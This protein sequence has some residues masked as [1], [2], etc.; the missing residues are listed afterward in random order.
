[1]DKLIEIAKANGAKSFEFSKN[2]H[3]THG[4]LRATIEQ[5]CSPLVEAL[6]KVISA[7]PTIDMTKPDAFKYVASVELSRKAL[8]AHTEIMGD[9]E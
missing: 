1:M 4:Q 6:E 7:N 3:M 5:V 2:I 9:K 8:A